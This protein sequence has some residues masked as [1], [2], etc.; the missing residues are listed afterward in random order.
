D[1]MASALQS[2][3]PRRS[4]TS[5]PDDWHWVLRSSANRPVLRAVDPNS[6]KDKDKDK[7]KDNASS[8]AG[9]QPEDRSLR[10]T[11]AFMAGAEGAGFGSAGE[12]TTAFALEKS[13][14]GAGTFSFD[15]N[16]GASSGDPS[17]VLR[18]AYAHDFGA[19]SR[20][21]FALIYRRFAAPGTFVGNS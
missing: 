14:F 16:I 10:A 5:E 21:T 18:A 12:M 2:L 17:G 13:L 15:G 11:V 8:V 19:S 3:P 1:A 20:P 9:E 7:D 6:D 4:A